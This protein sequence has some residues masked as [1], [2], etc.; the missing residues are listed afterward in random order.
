MKQIFWSLCSFIWLIA[1]L[2][3]DIHVHIAR[4]L[5]LKYQII[6]SEVNEI[7]HDAVYFVFVH[8][9]ILDFTSVLGNDR[10]MQIDGYTF[11]H[12]LHHHIRASVIINFKLPCE[13]DNDMFR[14]FESF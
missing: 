3:F 9:T 14:N 12:L 11:L 4:L 6:Y 13:F 1:S 5:P 10:S 2:P 7:M 8:E